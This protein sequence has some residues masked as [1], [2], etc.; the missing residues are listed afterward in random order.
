MFAALSYNFGG[1][2]SKLNYFAA[3]APIVNLKNTSNDLL[4]NISPHWNVVRKSLNLFHLYE[5]RDPKFDTFM[6]TFCDKW[7]SICDGISEWFHLDENAYN[8]VERT[9]VM[10]TRS[11][12]SGS[13]KQIIHYGQIA[14]TGVFK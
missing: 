7:S 6:H 2:Q 8:N 14:Y 1:L 12:S 9:D 4:K 11:G 5:L 3:L 13:S 10:N